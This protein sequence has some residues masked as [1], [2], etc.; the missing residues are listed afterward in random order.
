[1]ADIIISKLEYV[2][3]LDAQLTTRSEFIE[4]TVAKARCALETELVRLDLAAATATAAEAATEATTETTEATTETTIK[5]LELLLLWQITP[6]TFET[7]K[8]AIEHENAELVRLFLANSH[9]DPS[10][11]N[12]WAIRTASAEGYTDVVVV[13][14]ADP[15]VN[16]SATGIV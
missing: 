6:P 1:M 16:P 11:D 7:F 5:T 8:L 12:N 10:A 2:A 3:E 14:L 15:R 9:V 13:L 4:Q